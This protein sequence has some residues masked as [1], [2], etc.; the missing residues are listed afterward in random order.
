ME[1][2][3]DIRGGLDTGDS[4]PHSGD[5]VGQAAP[6]QRL[7]VAE[8]MQMPPYVGGRL[9][10]EAAEVAQAWEEFN[11][12]SGAIVWMAVATFVALCLGGWGV[13]V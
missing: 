12:K 6:V 9:P 2:Q 8:P 3:N 4:F 5:G 7:A 10:E 13:L 11:D 1:K